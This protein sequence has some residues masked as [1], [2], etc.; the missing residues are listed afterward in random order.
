MLWQYDSWLPYIFPL[1]IDAQPNC[2]VPTHM[3]RCD[4]DVRA[5]IALLLLFNNFFK[6]NQFYLYL[7]MHFE[8]ILTAHLRSPTQR[9]VHYAQG[10]LFFIFCSDSSQLR[11]KMEQWKL[12]CHMWFWYFDGDVPSHHSGSGQ[13]NIM[14]GPWQCYTVDSMP[15]GCVR[16]A[17]L[18]DAAVIQVETYHFEQACKQQQGSNANKQSFFSIVESVSILRNSILFDFIIV[19]FLSIFLP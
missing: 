10:K 9:V 4:Q 6:K 15:T 16:Y 5:C 18:C 7:L 11:R 2:S 14:R 17:K 12:L 8:W 19:L 1:R 13:R 3:C